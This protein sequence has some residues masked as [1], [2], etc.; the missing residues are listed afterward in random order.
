MNDNAVGA[1][2]FDRDLKVPRSMFNSR[3]YNMSIWLSVQ[4]MK[5]LPPAIRKNARQRVIFGNINEESIDSLCE[6]LSCSRANKGKI[7]KMIHSLDD[8]EYGFL[9]VNTVCKDKKNMFIRN[10]THRVL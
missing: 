4:Y 7:R 6:T 5:V 3:H 10:Y 9:F 8:F 2:R 1:M